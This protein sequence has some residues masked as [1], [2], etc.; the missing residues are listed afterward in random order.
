[1]SYSKIFSDLPE[2]TYEVIKYFKND[3]ST[4]H[5]CILVNRLWCRLAIP[6]LWE[7]PF[8]IPTGNYNFIGIYLHNLNGDLKAQLN[9][10]KI[11][12]NLFPSNTLFNYPIFLKYLYTWKIISSIEEW[13]K[14]VELEYSSILEFK[15]LIHMSLFKVII[16]N[17]VNIH[18]FDIH[19]T[20]HWSKWGD[21][22]Y[23][24][25]REILRTRHISY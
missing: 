8:S 3:F 4:L 14:D 7:N 6:L 2:L 21:V 15:R 19:I 16:K 24:Y 12:G 20:Y 10:Y 13:S 9:E 17:K 1:M 5:S 11:D 25:I 23:I 18:T 22:Q